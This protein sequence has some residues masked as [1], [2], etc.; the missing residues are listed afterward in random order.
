[1]RDEFGLL[2]PAPPFVFG[3]EGVFAYGEDLLE[4][5]VVGYRE[6][7]HKDLIQLVTG[8]DIEDRDNAPLSDDLAK[9]G[10]LAYLHRPEGRFG[11]FLPGVSELV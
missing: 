1:L 4:L 5:H 2:F 3:E 6:A 8:L 9:C 7:G 10:D 11:P